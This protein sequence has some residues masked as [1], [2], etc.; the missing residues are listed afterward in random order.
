MCILLNTSHKCKK[1]KLD[2]SLYTIRICAMTV[3]LVLT[4]ETH[5]SIAV[6]SKMIDS[7]VVSMESEGP[8][9]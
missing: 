3:S 6:M 8:I 9:V 1:K 7:L 4:I 5:S 2:F